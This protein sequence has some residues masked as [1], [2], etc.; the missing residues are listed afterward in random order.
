[1]QVALRPGAI[2]E[3]RS[4]AL[5]TSL[6]R[7]A[8]IVNAR[9]SSS[10]LCQLAS[11][12]RRRRVFRRTSHP[13]RWSG[14]EHEL[15]GNMG[16]EAAMAGVNGDAASNVAQLNGVST[17]TASVAPPSESIS[18]GGPCSGSI[19]RRQANLT[20]IDEIALYDRQI[21]LWGVQAQEK[22][23]SGLGLLPGQ[24]LTGFIGYEPP[25]SSWSA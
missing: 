1:M 17:Q 4:Q 5:S 6:A 7:L 15:A 13:S 21:R 8:W 19:L 23:V 20:F 14:T 12:K 2:F 9:F 11:K 25:I 16:S 3:L 10:S 18:A 22:C 24:T